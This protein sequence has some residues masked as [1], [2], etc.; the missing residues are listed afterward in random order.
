MVLMSLVLTNYSVTQVPYC[1]Y[2][3]VLA[4]GYIVTFTYTYPTAYSLLRG[5]PKR[6]AAHLEYNAAPYWYLH[7]IVDGACLGVGTYI[8]ASLPIYIQGIYKKKVYK[9]GS[10]ILYSNYLSTYV[11]VSTFGPSGLASLS[12]LRKLNRKTM[13]LTPAP[14]HL[15]SNFD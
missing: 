8:L 12:L 5:H 14:L 2:Q 13:M 4:Q 6:A 10:F 7:L 3:K 9:S 1:A 15:S 11:C